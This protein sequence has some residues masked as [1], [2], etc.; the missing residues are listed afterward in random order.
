MSKKKDS[1]AL[2]KQAITGSG[3]TAEDP[4]VIVSLEAVKDKQGKKRKTKTLPDFYVVDKKSG[5]GVHVEV[6]NGSGNNPHK[7]AQQRVVEAA[8]VEN[9]VQLTGDEVSAI[10]NEENPKK[11][12]QL[13]TKLL[14]L[15]TTLMLGY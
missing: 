3:F 6:T 7:K 4:R 8:G 5:Q 12:R 11:K 15:I 14:H 2:F 10:A 1:E 13:I 9:Y